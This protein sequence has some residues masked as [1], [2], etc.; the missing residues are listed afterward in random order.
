[1]C[2]CQSVC[3]CVSVCMLWLFSLH[4]ACQVA[5]VKWLSKEWR[6]SFCY[7]SGNEGTY[8]GCSYCLLFTMCCMK[9]MYK[10]LCFSCGFLLSFSCFVFVFW[11][12][13]LSQKR[14]I[15]QAC[16]CSSSWVNNIENCEFKWIAAEAAEAAFHMLNVFEELTVN[17][18]STSFFK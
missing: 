14:K 10:P 15:N 13:R 4:A 11:A 18:F 7:R 5:I 1:M 2:V 17:N 6:L 12:F 8:R 3:V 16:D 9:K